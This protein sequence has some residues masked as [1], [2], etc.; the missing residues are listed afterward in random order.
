MPELPAVTLPALRRQLAVST[1]L[2]SFPLSLDGPDILVSVATV[3]WVL[4]VSD[5]TVRRITDGPAWF[6]VSGRAVRSSGHGWLEYIERKRREREALIAAQVAALPAAALPA[7]PDSPRR[8]GRPRNADHELKH[9]RRQ[10]AQ[11][12]VRQP[13][14]EECAELGPAGPLAQ[15]QS[16][17]P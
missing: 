6:R 8:R 13:S 12:T 9:P 10:K 14:P 1:A 5:D 15:A 17:E 4:G 2:P 16:E 3:A 7:V 11:V